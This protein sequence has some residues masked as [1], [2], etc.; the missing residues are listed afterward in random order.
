M[1]TVLANFSG[2]IAADELYDGPFCVLFIVDNRT[3]RRLCYE[4]LEHTPTNKDILRFFGRFKQML[5]GRELT[6]KGI[7]TDG[8][9]LSGCVAIGS[10]Y[11]LFY[12]PWR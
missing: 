4:V 9:P 5:D 2:Y 8:S 10:T 6:L 3:F 7:T 1:N 11:L 12:R